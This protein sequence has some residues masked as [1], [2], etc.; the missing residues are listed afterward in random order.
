MNTLSLWTFEPFTGVL[1]SPRPDQ[2]G[3]KLRSVSGTRV[4]STTSRRELSSSFFF[5]FLRGKA[6]KEI[7]AIL[8]ET[9]ACFL[10]GRAQQLKWHHFCSCNR[11]SLFIGNT[12]SRNFQQIFRI[13]QS[14]WPRGLRRRSEAAHLLG[15]WIRIPPKAWMFCEHCVLAGRGL[16]D[17]PIPHP[18]QSYRVYLCMSECVI[19]KPQ[20]WD[21][22]RPS[23]DVA[24]LKEF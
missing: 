16:C 12:I 5:F 15:L 3:N 6:P 18:E 4:I 11:G 2:E 24:P 23:R 21:G 20:K 22:L 8:T 10:P 14:Q 1:I 13:S 19:T 7:D 17:G 9:L